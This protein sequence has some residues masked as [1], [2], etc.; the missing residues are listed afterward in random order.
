[1]AISTDTARQ[2]PIVQEVTYSP[3]AQSES[4]TATAKAQAPE[5]QPYRGDAVSAGASASPV[6]EARARIEPGRDLALQQRIVQQGGAT[7]LAATAPTREA[8]MSDGFEALLKD[9][10]DLPDTARMEEFVSWLENEAGESEE[11]EG[12]APEADGEE[13]LESEEGAHEDPLAAIGKNRGGGSGAGGRDGEQEHEGDQHL[14]HDK[15]PLPVAR[16]LSELSRVDGDVTHQFATLEFA[17]AYFDNLG[18]NPLILALLDAVKYEYES[19]DAARDIRAGRAAAWAAHRLAAALGDDPASVRDAAATVR[20]TYRQMLRQNP[21]L[22]QLF[23][24]VMKIDKRLDER[25]FEQTLN[26]FM[27]AAGSDLHSSGPSTDPM[28]LHLLLVE[29]GKLKNM[30]TIFESSRD[31]IEETDRVADPRDRGKMRSVELARALL[32]FCANTA[33]NLNDARALLGPLQ[34]DAQPLSQLV[35]VNMLNGLHARIPE[36]IVAIP[37]YRQQRTILA[38]WQRQSVKSEEDAYEKELASQA[39]TRPRRV[40]ASVA[41]LQ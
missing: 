31:L 29:L 5:P 36:A 19:S 23:D 13:L 9:L 33:V 25:S 34:N 8:E 40:A 35:Y 14:P 7:S 28:F 11:I 20:D 27:S 10:P 39:P 22:G 2:G 1:M 32:Y 17:R 41:R 4:R 26:A 37:A 21:H 38:S 16:V 24:M 18:T 12:E 6:S 3:A 30:Q 15:L